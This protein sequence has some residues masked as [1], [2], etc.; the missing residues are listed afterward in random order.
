MWY[1]TLVSYVQQSRPTFEAVIEKLP[2][3]QLRQ[4]AWHSSVVYRESSVLI[5]AEPGSSSEAR[6]AF[7]AEEILS[8]ATA[9]VLRV[10]SSIAI[11]S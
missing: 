7:P 5:Q 2:D 9:M 8:V 6:L 3:L 1:A 4:P 10:F 11:S